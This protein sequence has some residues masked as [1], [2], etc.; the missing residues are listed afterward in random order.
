MFIEKYSEDD[1]D[2]DLGWRKITGFPELFK[3]PI[4]NLLIG[5]ISE[6][7]ESGAGMHILYL[8]N[9][10]GP[11][12]TFEKQW[13]VRHILLIPNTIRTEADSEEKI[14]QIRDQILNGASFAELAAEF[15]DDPGSKQEGGNLGWA[16]DGVYAPEFEQAIKNANLNEITKPFLTQFGW[17]ILEVLDT[18][19]EDKTNE[20]IEDQAFSYLFNRK[21]DEELESH[22]QELRAEAFI[23]I[24]EFD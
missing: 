1:N 8:E 19:I 17:H 22:L 15:S 13:N 12:V 21:F 4:N 18:R 10:R 9:K 14:I 3:E 16:G 20:R 23:E 6:P 24:K 11:T 7:I 2:G 5:D